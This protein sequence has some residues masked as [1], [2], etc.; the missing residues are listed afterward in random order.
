[1][2]PHLPDGAREPLARA[3]EGDFCHAYRAGAWIVRVA[4]HAMAV[5]ITREVLS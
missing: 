5:E 4:K 3:G 2:R 1:V